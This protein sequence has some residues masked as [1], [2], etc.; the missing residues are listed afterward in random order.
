MID[1][2]LKQS[3]HSSHRWTFWFIT[4]LSLLLTG[5]SAQAVTYDFPDNLPSTCSPVFFSATVQ[6]F[7]QYT[8]NGLV[9]GASD[10][11]T[12]NATRPNATESVTITS[13]SAISIGD[14]AKVNE[15]GSAA[16][17][18]FKL[19]GSL[20]LG[21]TGILNA[22]VVSTSTISIAKDSLIGGSIMTTTN[23]GVVTTA[24]HSTVGGA[25][26][27]T[28]GAITV[29]ANSTV[30]S[31]ITAGIGAVDIGAY[32]Q[33]D[34]DING[35]LGA[36][37]IGSHAIL[38]L[39]KPGN[40][41]TTDGVVTIATYS[42]IGFIHT[43][44]GDI[45]VFDHSQVKGAI[46]TIKGTIVIYTFV[47]VGGNVIVSAGLGNIE[48]GASSEVCG[49][50]RN[51][52]YGTLTL[53]ASVQVAGNVYTLQSAITINDGGSVG[54]YAYIAGDGVMTMTGTLVGGDITTH[55]GV[56]TLTD[57]LVRGTV[58]RL[59]AGGAVVM[60]RSVDKQVNLVIPGPQYCPADPVIEVTGSTA[61]GLFDC[62]ETGGQTAALYTQL[63]GT[64]FTFDIA[65]LKIDKTIENNYVVAGDPPKYTRVELFDDA[66]PPI[67]CAAYINPV[68][69]KT[70]V[71][72][73]RL[74]GRAAPT[75]AFNLSNVYQK[76]R[77]RVTECT[78]NTCT[79]ISATAKQSCSSDQFSVRPVA[80]TLISSANAL[81]PS[82]TATPFIKAGT[83]FNLS[84]STISG[85]HY[86]GVLTLDSNKLTVENPNQDITQP[87][88]GV[89]GTLTP[90]N[91]T[92]NTAAVNNAT[93]SEVG[94]LY[95]APGAYRDDSFTAVDSVNGD[96]MTSTV[97]DSHLSTVLMGAQ[98]GCSIGNIN[99]VSLG[100][101]VPD[102]LGVVG[103]VITRSDLQTTESQAVPFTYMD[104]PMQLALTVTAYNKSEGATFNYQGKFAKLN[105]T[106]WSATDLS[107]WTCS[108]LSCMG[109]SANNGTMPLTDRLAIDTTRLNSKVPRNTTTL[110]GSID[111]WS[112]GSSY[113]TVN[114]LLKRY[115]NLDLKINPKGYVSPDGPYDNLKLG[116]KP[117]DLDGVTLP[118]NAASDTLHCV[119][120]NIT[121]GL[122]NT[123]C[124]FISDNDND[125][126]RKIA[127]TPVRFGQLQVSNAY[128]SER[129]DLPILVEVQYW[130][131][132][133]FATNTFDN[134]TMLTVNNLVEGNYQGALS[135]ATLTTPTFRVIDKNDSCSVSSVLSG[136]MTAGKS[137][138][139]LSKPFIIGS[140]DLLINLGNQ[141]STANC[142]ISSLTYGSSVSATLPYLSGNGC[143]AAYDKDPVAHI[144]WG[145]Y[146]DNGK[147]SNGL[148]YFR[149][150]Y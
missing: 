50:V 25:I 4:L 127:E 104:E 26:N 46:T 77:C 42:I 34:G 19:A 35:G 56:I 1:K 129:L 28:D 67:S 124:T 20:T 49:N 17:L 92:A 119:N 142:L 41:T 68:D 36:V 44:N 95:L 93:Y 113:F 111:A 10:S 74:S 126:R 88:N 47:I 2:S 85:D 134:N 96:C 70:V 81:A 64:S 58:A 102:H 12:V 21:D 22:N 120:L 103:A 146:K 107:H 66:M 61:S 62:L 45:T 5:F 48:I 118:P 98:Y 130:N 99:A 69:V 52:G 83:L 39:S 63:A 148:I 78:D 3:T 30:H 71:F 80:V 144:T 141:E 150:V 72:N 40:I 31:S 94:Y 59:G 24:A 122:E 143:G 79:T 13:G 55:V 100:R 38:G 43:G 121:T 7:S 147:G 53:M 82:S 135:G 89:I 76:L 14:F 11:I 109:L 87:N 149:E 139:L 29:G 33:I 101:F 60:T 106:D 6:D 140:F 112:K 57:T 54:S 27:A 86:S 116:A 37:T 84:A 133:S 9:L 16:M 32:S 110:G 15:T 97:S 115:V 23:T 51:E 91:L 117:L 8:C 65:A 123:R 18:T 145:I 131:G 138:L 90:A 114:I 132:S 75:S 108:D 73:S 136:V 125:L 128:G 137:C 105:T